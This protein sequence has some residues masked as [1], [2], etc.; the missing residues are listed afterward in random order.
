MW[1]GCHAVTLSGCWAKSA[2]TLRIDSRF[3]Q[4]PLIGLA[5]RA[6]GTAVRLDDGGAGALELCVVEA[7]N[8]AIEH[9]YGGQPGHVVEVEVTLTAAALRVE[10]RD[11]GHRMDWVA[12]TARAAEPLTEGGRG[13]VIMR[14]LMDEV[15]YASGR[16]RNV[17]T[18]VKQLPGEA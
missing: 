16:G 6:I 5:V 13:V 4:V 3:D 10:V 7:V 2:L 12:A 11:H 15:S 1:T 9:A 14:S 8:N 17:L 18:L